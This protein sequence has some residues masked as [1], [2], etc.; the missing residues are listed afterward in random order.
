[1]R[2]KHMFN[3]LKKYFLF[4]YLNL[5]LIKIN[6]SINLTLIL[7]IAVR[8]LIKLKST[9]VRHHPSFLFVMIEIESFEIE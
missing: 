5:M 3:D 7:K 8:E 6:R 9:E 4:K 2:I 1:M